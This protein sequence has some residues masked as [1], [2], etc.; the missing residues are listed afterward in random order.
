MNSKFPLTRQKA[1]DNFSGLLSGKEKTEIKESEFITQD[2]LSKSNKDDSKRSSDHMDGTNELDR[3][4]DTYMDGDTSEHEDTPPGSDVLHSTGKE[5]EEIDPINL[6]DVQHEQGEVSEDIQTPEVV[7]D[8]ESPAKDISRSTPKATINKSSSKAS[9][10]LVQSKKSS[11]K[12][13]SRKG[14]KLNMKEANSDRTEAQKKVGTKVLSRKVNTLNW[15]ERGP[16][17][18]KNIFRQTARVVIQKKKMDLDDATSSSSSD[19]EDK[20]EH[21]KVS[22][23]TYH[24]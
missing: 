18:A 5:E 3:D 10:S 12:I 21:I 14:P 7:N 16:L 1:K 11:S 17:G 4:T 13:V 8:L 23:L 20:Q 6:T 22:V 15:R 24:L 19:N 9:I 2:S